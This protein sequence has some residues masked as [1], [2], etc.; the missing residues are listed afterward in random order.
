[1]HWPLFFALHLL[2]LLFYVAA[3]W[4]VFHAVRAAFGFGKGAQETAVRVL[5]TWQ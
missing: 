2:A 4:A 5:E 1:M 3:A